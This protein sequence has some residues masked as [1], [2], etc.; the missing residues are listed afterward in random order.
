MPF[1]GSDQN[2]VVQAIDRM[3]AFFEGGRRW[4]KHRAINVRGDR[5]LIGAVDLAATDYETSIGV[6]RC[7]AKA[8]PPY[9]IKNPYHS[10]GGDSPLYWAFLYGQLP[11]YNDER[12]TTYADIERLLHKAREIAKEKVNAV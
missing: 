4:I 7:L 9:P 11:A 8:L 2:R 12:T 10:D 3:E 5:C 6:R 1:D